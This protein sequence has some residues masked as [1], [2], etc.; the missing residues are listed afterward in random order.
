MSKTKY[1]PWGAGIEAWVLVNYTNTV[2]VSF[3]DSGGTRS[4]NK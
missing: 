3:T 2:S 4:L 1:N